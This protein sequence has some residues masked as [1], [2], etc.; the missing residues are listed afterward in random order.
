MSVESISLS[1]AALG[2]RCVVTRLEGF[3]PMKR[4]LMDLGLVE[5]TEVSPLFESIFKNPRAYHIRG[6]VIA[7][8]REDSDLI[9]VKMLS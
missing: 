3:G 6:A 9:K 8:R 2:S 5:G 7:L 1:N 4:R